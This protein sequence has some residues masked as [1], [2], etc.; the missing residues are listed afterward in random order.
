MTG[1]HLLSTVHQVESSQSIQTLLLSII[2][3]KS[4]LKISAFDF[5][6]SRYMAKN[7]CEKQ[8][9]VLEELSRSLQKMP[10]DVGTS[11][12]SSLSPS[13]RG[14]RRL[15]SV[16]LPPRCEDSEECMDFVVSEGKL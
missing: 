2:T 9:E 8:S 6:L 14:F 11:G 4:E 5:G 12:H 1:W 15:K 16:Q 3:Q 7:E 10:T 13:G